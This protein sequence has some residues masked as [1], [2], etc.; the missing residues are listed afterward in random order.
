MR[1]IGSKITFLTL[2]K[3]VLFATFITV[4]VYRSFL[5]FVLF[6]GLLYSSVD[7]NIIKH[8]ARNGLMVFLMHMDPQ[9]YHTKIGCA[10]HAHIRA[11]SLQ[12]FGL[13]VNRGRK[14]RSSYW[15]QI[16]I[17]LWNLHM[18]IPKW[19]SKSKSDQN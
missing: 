18:L 10:S 13:A 2:F 15:T 11:H 9:S 1:I 8:K 12:S 17:L 5:D 19:Y 14:W 6:K 4:L 7:P 3:F 16:K